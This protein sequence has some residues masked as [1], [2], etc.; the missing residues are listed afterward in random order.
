[1]KGR[2]H[3]NKAADTGLKEAAGYFEHAL[4]LD[5][6]F[7]TAYAAL[8]RVHVAAADYYVDAPRRALEA[9]RVAAERALAL[10]PSDSE[11]HL[12]LAEVRK[13]VDWNW[14]GA[15]AGYRFA[16]AFNPCSEAA[17]RLYGLFLAARGR[18]AEA[19]LSATRACDLDPLCLVVNTSAA[20][21]RY[22][23]RD[24]D[25]AID[26]CRHTL[27]MDRAF[28]PAHRVMAAA[29]LQVGRLREA[30]DALTVAV[31]ARPDDPV[32][33]AWLAHASAIEGD[34]ARAIALT[35]TLAEAST[36]RYV[37]RYHVALAEAA[38]GDTD[39]ACA[40]LAAAFEARDPAIANLRL[41]PRFEPL[42]FDAQY[43][44]LV[45]RLGLHHGR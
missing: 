35:E 1:M 31:A 44:T 8:S 43:R 14:D 4:A 32:S 26:W 19:A 25:L 17:H 6:A 42:R 27:D 16:L 21:V 40:S 24:Y 41:E 37:S 7:A 18:T 38:L 23:A 28:A 13:T 5:P 3:W 12:A 30:V 45:D 39:R 34:K 33:L 15:E 22:L 20:W 11:A 36:R 9:A 2:Y 10:D 29:L